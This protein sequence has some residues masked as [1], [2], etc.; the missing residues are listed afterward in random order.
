MEKLHHYQDKRRSRDLLLRVSHSSKLSTSLSFLP[1]STFFNLTVPKI[2]SGK[3]CSLYPSNK[4][5]KSTTKVLAYPTRIRKWEEIHICKLIIY[6]AANAN[7]SLLTIT[8]TNHTSSNGTRACINHELKESLS[9]EVRLLDF[10]SHDRRRAPHS[11]TDH[12]IAN[13]VLLF[14]K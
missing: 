12:E 14:F 2:R 10:I 6:T 13:I 7:Q 9:L 8:N 3:V 11:F 1:N 4:N 5:A